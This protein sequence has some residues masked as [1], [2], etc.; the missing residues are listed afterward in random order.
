MGRRKKPAQ[1]GES[2]L[3]QATGQ[4]EVLSERQTQEI[5]DGTKHLLEQMKD[6]LP[7][8]YGMVI[9]IIDHTLAYIDKLD[10]PFSD[11][12]LRVIRHLHLLREGAKEQ[13][14]IIKTYSGEKEVQ[15]G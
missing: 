5:I 1:E 4:G 13:V 6:G 3:F 14:R 10:A 11:E 12:K 15:H 8:F 9:E 2:N 7:K